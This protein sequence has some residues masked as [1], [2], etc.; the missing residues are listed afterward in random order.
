MK[1]RS[2][3]PNQTQ[4]KE[5][6]NGQA[7]FER[8]VFCCGQHRTHRPAMPPPS[9]IVNGEYNRPTESAAGFGFR[10][11][12][13]VSS[14]HFPP[15]LRLESAWGSSDS[16]EEREGSHSVS[17]LRDADSFHSGT[18]IGLERK[19]RSLQET[20]LFPFAISPSERLHGRFSQP[21][22]PTFYAIAVRPRKVQATPRRKVHPCPTSRSRLI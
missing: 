17:R 1:R 2:N 9:L 11:G 6:G 13:S 8:Q 20:R 14:S 4:K 22:L 10:P 5:M 12:R 3:G 7:Q 19:R 16:G 15:S 21:A 18:Q